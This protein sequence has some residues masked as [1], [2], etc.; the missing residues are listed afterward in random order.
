MVRKGE[1]MVFK[2]IAGK[3][4]PGRIP[5]ARGGACKTSPLRDLENG[6]RQGTAREGSRSNK[7]E[8]RVRGSQGKYYATL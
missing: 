4:V 5:F 8:L 1:G 3:A 2:G 7:F 6:S